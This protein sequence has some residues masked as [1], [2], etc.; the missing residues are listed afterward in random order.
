[1]D[2]P[3]NHFIDIT[4][5]VTAETPVWPGDPSAELTTLLSMEKGD[6]CHLSRL[7]FGL[8]TGTHVDAPLHFIQ[9]GKDVS[10]LDLWK[11]QG[12][13]LVVDA[14]EEERITSV[15]LEKLQL[16]SPKRILFK[17]FSGLLPRNTAVLK[18]PYNAL[19]RS[20]AE[21]LTEQGVVLCGIDGMT[22]AIEEEL[23]AV[24]RILLEKEIVIVENLILEQLSAGIYE[25]L[26]M[27]MLIP[28][29]EAAPARVLIKKI[30]IV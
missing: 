20:A 4:V 3:D 15:F 12:E 6:S 27:P 28:C 22:I 17:T 25:I 2:K 7:S 5:P 23:S 9:G 13:V 16:A 26:V 30:P 21:W 24:H 10:S 18:Q 1:M 8:H 11:M 19:D 14:T 29:A